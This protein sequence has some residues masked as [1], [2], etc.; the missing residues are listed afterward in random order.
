[1]RIVR[2]ANFITGSSGGLRTA[3]RELG[4]GYLAA[5]HEPVLVVPG[6]A[7]ADED[8]AQGRV[9]TVAG[10]VVPGTGGYRVLL[11]RSRV[12]RLLAELAPDRLEVSDRTTLRWTGQWARRHGVP[13]LMVSHETLDGLLRLPFG[14]RSAGPAKQTERIA[15]RLNAATAAAYDRVVCTTDWAAREFARIGAD[16]L[17]RVPLG[18]DL[19]QFHPRRYDETVRE[20]YTPD[21]ELLVLHCARLSAEKCPERVLAA[22]AALRDRGVP[23]VGVI[24][25]TGPRQAGLRAHAVEAG[26]TV[27]FAN[28]VG[29]RDEVA[30]LLASADVVIAPGPVETFGLAALESLASGTPVVV[31]AESALPEVI[32]DAG[33]AVAGGG[34][35]YADAICELAGR[36]AAARRPAARRRAEGFPW[37]AAVDGFLR[38]HRGGAGAD[39][40]AGAARSRSESGT[41]CDSAG[42]GHRSARARR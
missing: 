21:G 22:L 15:D 18:V 34:Q 9:I 38:A 20:Q 26:L 6:A 33:L 1:M 29:D 4:T 5:G 3:L 24:V 8:T 7:D 11:G 19:D 35:E 12:R 41:A 30:R 25:G 42:R 28:Y 27:H 10:P 39:Q 16:N 23:A 14:A 40:F 36:P 13:A 17:V 37:S 2:L 31:A 32:G